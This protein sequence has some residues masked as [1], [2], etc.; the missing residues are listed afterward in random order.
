MDAWALRDAD[1]KMGRP[2]ASASTAATQRG[3]KRGPRQVD[4]ELVQNVAKL[5]LQTSA[6]VRSH[7][8]SLQHCI[9][10]DTTN[11]I[12]KAM[13]SMGRRY[14]DAKASHMQVLEGAPH[15]HVWAAM[16]QQIID[17]KAAQGPDA[18]APH[19]HAKTMA[20]PQQL[21]DQVHVCMATSTHQ[22]GKTKILISVSASLF[23][24]LGAMLR[25][26]QTQGGVL[27]HGAPPRSPL[28]RQVAAALRSAS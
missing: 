6:I 12:V 28:E 20:S 9:I 19:A 15:I 16:I 8:A 7:S 24:V 14:F 5:A 13:T 25:T 3:R 26:L 2:P 21:E 10:I 27:K 17:S 4:D 23:G 1:V 22:E 18:E 11:P